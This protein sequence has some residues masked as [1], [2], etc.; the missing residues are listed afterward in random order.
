MTLIGFLPKLHESCRTM[1]GYLYFVSQ[2]LNISFLTRTL[3]YGSYLSGTSIAVLPVNLY[4][5]IYGTY[6]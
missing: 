2:F 5:A 6:L 1:I 3:V 4:L